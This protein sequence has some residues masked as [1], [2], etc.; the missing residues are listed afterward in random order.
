MHLRRLYKYL[1][2]QDELAVS[3]VSYDVAAN[4]FTC[5]INYLGRII[6]LEVDEDG[7]FLLRTRIKDEE[8]KKIDYL[9]S[10]FETL[11]KK[12]LKL[13]MPVIKNQIEQGL[14]PL[15]QQ[16]FVQPEKKIKP[17]KG[18]ERRVCGAHT[19]ITNRLTNYEEK[20][21]TYYTSPKALNKTF[22]RLY[23]FIKA[24]EHALINLTEKMVDQFN[25]TTE[26]NK[27][28]ESEHMDID[29]LK[30]IT[31]YLADKTKDV[32]LMHS[33]IEQMEL[34]FNRK[35]KHWKH[36]RMGRTEKQIAKTLKL[37]ER[38][39][40]AQED[41]KYV[42]HLWNLLGEF[43]DRSLHILEITTSRQEAVE[44]NR[45]QALVSAE[46]AQVV[47]ASLLSILI[48]EGLPISPKLQAVGTIVVWVVLFL[49]ISGF[50]KI[51]GSRKKIKKYFKK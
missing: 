12:I 30:D 20:T 43:S 23:F 45:L 36:H 1:R 35:H 26:V 47:A 10:Y 14:M 29:T 16:L 4:T 8:V 25:K 33:R 24:Y 32:S 13:T 46:T 48:A 6:N 51:I 39:D 3:K 7:V 37:D 40:N 38:Y 11:F 17:E 49:L 50:F 5:E 44:S 28:L 42:R 27:Q 19:I 34:N 41:Y 9:T 2:E 21:V 31:K 22:L 15:Q 18:F